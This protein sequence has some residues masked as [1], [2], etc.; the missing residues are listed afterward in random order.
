MKVYWILSLILWVSA[1]ASQASHEV[2]CDARLQPIN[3]PEP[4]SSAAA[5][6]TLPVAPMSPRSLP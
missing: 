3:L 4:K 5:A 1:C 6:P 2:R